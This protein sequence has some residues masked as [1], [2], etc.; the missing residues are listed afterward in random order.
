MCIYEY[1]YILYVYFFYHMYIYISYQLV[2]RISDCNSRVSRSICCLWCM[3]ICSTNL[4]WVWELQQVVLLDV[5][6]H[7]LLKS[8]LCDRGVF[9][10][11]E[12]F[13][14]KQSQQ[15]SVN[16]QLSSTHQTSNYSTTFCFVSVNFIFFHRILT[17]KNLLLP[18]KSPFQELPLRSSDAHLASSAMELFGV[19]LFFPKVRGT[20]PQ[21]VG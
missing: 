8:W 3:Q 20:V 7:N 13:L 14:L 5:E 10:F 19:T 17:K 4:S 1:I 9:W 2:I 18:K 11:K 21:K 12:T 15:K 16:L 6:W